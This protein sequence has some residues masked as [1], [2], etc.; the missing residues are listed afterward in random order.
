MRVIGLIE[1]VTR[2]DLIEN[3]KIRKRRSETGGRPNREYRTALILS[4]NANWI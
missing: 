2:R 1:G 4:L 3:T